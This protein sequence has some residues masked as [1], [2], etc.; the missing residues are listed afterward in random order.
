MATQDDYSVYNEE[1]EEEALEMDRED[2]HVYEEEVCDMSPSI[3]TI[4]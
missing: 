1:E 3:T 2:D 4:I